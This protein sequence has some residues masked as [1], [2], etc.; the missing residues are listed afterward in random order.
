MAIYTVVFSNHLTLLVIFTRAIQ[1]SGNILC[2]R[3]KCK[4]KE[5]IYIFVANNNNKN[6]IL[7]ECLW[8]GVIWQ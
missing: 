7:C 5:R 1:A 4:I 2:D 6:G 3:S 8:D